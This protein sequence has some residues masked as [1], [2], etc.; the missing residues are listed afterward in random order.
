MKK[1]KKMGKKKNYNSSSHWGHAVSVPGSVLTVI[2]KFTFPHLSNTII[3][4]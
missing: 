4:C 2:D 1:K 3:R